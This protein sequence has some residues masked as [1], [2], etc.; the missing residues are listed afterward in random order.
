M[1]QFYKTKWKVPRNLLKKNQKLPWFL[2]KDAA[3][4]NQKMICKR[5]IIISTMHFVFDDN[6]KKQF[7][8]TSSKKNGAEFIRA[9]GSFLSTFM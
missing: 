6:N 7:Y 8:M 9:R 2:Y 4:D 1:R 5:N 3:N